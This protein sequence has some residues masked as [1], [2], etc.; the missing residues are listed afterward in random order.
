MR[1]FKPL[2]HWH[3][4][5]ER[6]KPVYSV[7]FAPH[8]Q[9]VTLADPL[10]MLTCGE[11]ICSWEIV[12]GFA[13]DTGEPKVEFRAEFGWEQH[14][15]DVYNV[16]SSPQDDSVLAG[17][18]TGTIVI[19]KKIPHEKGWRKI[20]G[21]QDAQ[22]EMS[23]E[24]RPQTMGAIQ[25]Q[26]LDI[27]GLAW[28]P[29]GRFYVAAS[30]DSSLQAVVVDISTKG[31]SKELIHGDG[32][33]LG[34]A[35]DPNSK[36]VITLS[37][38][39]RMR[40]FEPLCTDGE[41]RLKPVYDISKDMNGDWMFYDEFAASFR[42]RADFSSD[43][44]LLIVPAGIYK[45]TPCS[46]VFRFG[47]NKFSRPVA[48]LPSNGPTVCVK[49]CPKRFALR[50]SETAAG[51]GLNDT[52][53]NGKVDE[54]VIMGGDKLDATGSDQGMD[55]STVSGPKQSNPV[56]VSGLKCRYI[57]AVVTEYP[58]EIHLYDTEMARPFAVMGNL[59]VQDV[60]DLA[61]SSDGRVLVVTSGDGFVSFVEF[62]EAELGEEYTPIG[63]NNESTS[64]AA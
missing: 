44:Q 52:L 9:P 39:R 63:E 51:S 19:W 56:I 60:T 28:S 24:W 54:D 58:L 57:F 20:M 55:V 35:W 50:N 18:G 26:K 42:R 40:V 59:H 23:E 21:Q 22:I 45:D 12:P 1:I 31:I 5:R 64:A 2:L 32:P 11:S 36:Y 17:D 62:D 4:A 13:S 25:R 3:G 41:Y 47:A 8:N 46:Y 6:S 49:F 16:R 48:V 61:W 15:Y 34:C 33:V 37:T 29:D 7:T 14:L 53:V 38:D 10:C 43:G 30:L 27:T